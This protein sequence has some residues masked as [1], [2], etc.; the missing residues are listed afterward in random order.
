MSRAR[1]QRFTR[2]AG[3]AD[4]TVRLGERMGEAVDGGLVVALVGPLGAGKTTF[5]QGLCRG[6]GVRDAVTS[7]TFVLEERYSGRLPVL[8]VDLYRLEYESEVEELGLYDRL[9]GASVVLVEWADR[10]PDLL[11]R[12]DVVV[13]IRPE[14]AS[15]VRVVAIE[16]TEA[17]AR[18]VPAGAAREG[19]A[20]A[21]SAASPGDAASGE[22]DA[23][24]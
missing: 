8:H 20:R 7:P 14:P 10:A 23:S 13:E 24:S 17:A 1:T 6:L 5:A 4:D 16:T 11:R 12:A 18:V 3:T 22:D 19:D 2:V 15:P 9:D 21:P